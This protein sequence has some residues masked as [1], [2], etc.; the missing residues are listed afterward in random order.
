MCI[1][2]KYI[3]NKKYASTKKNKGIIP[4]CNDE[5]LMQVKAKCGYCSECRKEKFNNWK[6]RLIEECKKWNTIHFVTLTFNEEARIRY[7]KLA[8]E[9]EEVNKNKAQSKMAI[10]HWLENIRK[11]KKKMGKHF[12]INE[13]GEKGRLHLHGI[14]F[15]FTEQEIRKWERNGFVYI[16][17]YVNEKTINYISK[18]M[19]KE[20]NLHPDFNQNIFASPGIGASY[21]NEYRVEQHHRIKNGQMDDK[22]ILRSGA[23]ITLPKYLRNKIYTDE[24]R[25][26]MCIEKLNEGYVYIKGEKIEDTNEELIY[27]VLQYY[28]RREQQLHSIAIKNALCYKKNN[29][30]LRRKKYVKKFGGY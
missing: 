15:G 28:Q 20:D 7:E 1:Y 2:Y 19:L 16:G 6:I 27:N 9:S 3:R 12:L 10:R 26:Q 29:K 22:Y 30:L 5:R 17:E 23:K 24:E 18:Y 21:V 8:E 13:I 14:L 25:E 11:T 4:I